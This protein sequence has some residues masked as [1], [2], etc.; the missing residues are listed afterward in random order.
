[1]D[2]EFG[3]TFRRSM[4]LRK[5]SFQTLARSRRVLR[6]LDFSLIDSTA[7]L[8]VMILERDRDREL[9]DLAPNKEISDGKPD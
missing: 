1:M 3:E 2:D 4:G 7:W 6:E 9:F 5:N 8:C